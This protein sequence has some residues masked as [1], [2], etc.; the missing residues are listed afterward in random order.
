MSAAPKIGTVRLCRDCECEAADGQ[1]DCLRCIAD[2]ERRVYAREAA[3]N[4]RGVD[5]RGV[6]DHELDRLDGHGWGRGRAQ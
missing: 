2:R 5:E 1:L 3:M 6:T 4:R